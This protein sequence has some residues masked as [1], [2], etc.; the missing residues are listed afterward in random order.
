MK[1]TGEVTLSVIGAILNL[2]IVAGGAVVIAQFSDESVRQDF[3]Q[4]LSQDPEM[5]TA[6][7][8]MMLD[9]IGSSGW[10]IVIAALIAL[11]MGVVSAVSLKGNKK[12]KLAGILL[13]IA[14][15]INTIVTFLIGWLP[16]LLYLIAGIM[17]LVRKP[18]NV[19]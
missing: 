5:N 16:A 14:A 11:V 10:V 6:N 13:I 12:P 2:F 7:S 9:A 17:S 4:Q 19:E 1:R 8:N 15:I 18:R 3:K